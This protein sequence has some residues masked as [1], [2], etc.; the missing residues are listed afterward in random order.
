MT[1]LALPDLNALATH[2]REQLER[3]KYLLLYAYNGTGKTR[4][5][6]EFKNIGK[7]G[8]GRDTLYFNAFTEDLFS[9][10]NDLQGDSDRVLRMNRD[11][12]FLEGLE[13]LEME[14]RIRPILQRYADFN[15]IID[16]ANW[17]VNFSRIVPAEPN[18]IEVQK[19]KISRGE[20]NTFIWCFFLAIVQ[21][22][23]D[24]QEA[25]DWVKYVYIDDPISSLDEHNAIT[26]GSHLAQI[27]K[28]HNGQMKFVISTHH[29][30]FFNVMYNELRKAKTFFLSRNQAPEQWTLAET[31]ETPFFYHVAMLADLVEAD[32]S[33]K[34]YTYHFNILRSILE[35][36]ASF[37]GYSDFS[38]CIRV[39]EDDEHDG[40][41]IKRIV[42]I[43]NHAP[44]SLYDPK[45]MV[46]E[47]KQHFKRVLENF[48][49]DFPFNR[50]LVAPEVEEAAAG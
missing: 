38:D 20:E 15:F 18:P 10:N 2:L 3:K 33:G 6:M 9:W 41:I 1:K 27:L 48:L 5:S 25:Y 7:Q 35:R 4:L 24:G 50:A 39:N 11:S 42:Q 43:L 12:S 16:Y 36:T 8:D 21:L 17:T 37:H 47:N 22:A 45:E 34:V 14:N 49:E 28:S 30:L 40:A 32:R 29:A 13:E 44:Y 31:D 23:M 19:I 26:V 46:Q